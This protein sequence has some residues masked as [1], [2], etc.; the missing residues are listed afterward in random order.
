[1]ADPVIAV[2]QHKL[3]EKNR[4]LSRIAGWLQHAN[5]TLR[6][7]HEEALR[8]G[9]DIDMRPARTTIKGAIDQCAHIYQQ[10]KHHEQNPTG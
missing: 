10:G 7:A 8:F 2:G 3:D 4:A 5:D 1:M 6:Q 9:L